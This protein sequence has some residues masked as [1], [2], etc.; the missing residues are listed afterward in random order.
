MLK[1]IFMSFHSHFIMKSTIRA[2]V[3]LLSAFTGG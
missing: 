3:V 2:Q 1:G